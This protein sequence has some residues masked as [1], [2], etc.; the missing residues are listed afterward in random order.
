MIKILLVITTAALVMVGVLYGLFLLSLLVSLFYGT[1]YIGIPKKSVREI[2]AFGELDSSDIFYDLGSGDGRVLTAAAE[3][4]K[5]AR[6]AGF[7]MAPLPYFISRIRIALKRL[8]EHITIH[9]KSFLK[10]DLSSASFVYVYL[11]RELLNEK[12]APKL[13]RELRHSTKVLSCSSPID[14]TRYP[15]FHLL[16]TSKIGNITVFLYEKI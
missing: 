2:L 13:A 15:Q 16:K 5:I 3:Y 10:A 8:G 4:F 7:E 9:Y 14:T 12:V 11:Y 6:A 1:P